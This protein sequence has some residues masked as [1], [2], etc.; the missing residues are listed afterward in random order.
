LRRAI[1]RDPSSVVIQVAGATDTARAESV[2][3]AAVEAFCRDAY[4]HAAASGVEVANDE[5]D[6][7]GPSY[8]STFATPAGPCVYVDCH[9]MDP[10]VTL[11][12][13]AMISTALTD[14]GIEGWKLTRPR[15]NDLP[16][17]VRFEKSVGPA[18]VLRLFGRG[19]GAGIV[20]PT[21]PPNGYVDAAHT[22][23]RRHH[24]PAERL[25][26]LIAVVPFDLTMAQLDAVARAIFTSGGMLMTGELSSLVRVVEADLH[27]M[28]LGVGGT[29]TTATDLVAFG[30]ELAD[31]ARDLAPS[32]AYAFVDFR[33]LV[34]SGHEARHAPCH[35]APLDVVRWLP[36]RVAYDAF[37]FQ[38]LSDVH[39]SHLPPS[40]QARCEQLSGDR[41]A[42]IIG[43]PEDW[44]PGSPNLDARLADG[45]KLLEPLLLDT[46]QV[47]QRLVP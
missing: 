40:T 33:S 5:G 10:R 23:L 24:Q 17:E 9:D 47:S 46:D 21:E 8:W 26:A 15:W 1:R 18:A 13:P 36:E 16:S 25:R 3:A 44:L 39:L 2:L 14:A 4:L 29:H 43:D 38:I 32:T 34:G 6:I 37:W 7:G 42:L 27:T 31:I 35:S 12:L 30:Q 20:N 45:R 28:R 22:W 41:Y 19:T 11:V